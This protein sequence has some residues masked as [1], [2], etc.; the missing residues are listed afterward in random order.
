MKLN[1]LK[2]IGILILIL[3]NNNFSNISTSTVKLPAYDTPNIF[4]VLQ[5]GWSFL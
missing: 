3:L 2:R 4:S 1:E 5:V